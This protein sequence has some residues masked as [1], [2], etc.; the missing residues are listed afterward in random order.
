MKRIFCQIYACL[1]RLYPRHFRETFADEMAE[2]FNTALASASAEGHLAFWGVLSWELVHLPYSLFHEWKGVSIMPSF[3]HKI[4]FPPK[5]VRWSVRILFAVF[6]IYALLA[7]GAY[8]AYEVNAHSLDN[9]YSWYYSY[10]HNPDFIS[11]R[12]PISLFVLIVWLTTPLF[13]L[14]CGSITAFTLFASWR[15]MNTR[16]RLVMAAALIAGFSVMLS[17]PTPIGHV[18]GLWVY[19]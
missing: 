6:T 8:C 14:S 1:L 11:N 5:L 13:L 12:L 18:V 9:T 7:I 19:D 17:M 15:H 2:V 4:T 10:D 3:I 16:Q